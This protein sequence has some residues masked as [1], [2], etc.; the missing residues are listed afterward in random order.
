MSKETHNRHRDAFE[1]SM[2]ERAPALDANGD[3]DAIGYGYKNPQLTNMF[4]VFLDGII[5]GQQQKLEA[6]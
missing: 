6:E 1:A 3:R 4:I 5:Y 2:A